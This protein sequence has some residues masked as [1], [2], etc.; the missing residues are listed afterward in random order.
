MKNILDKH[1]EAYEGHNQYDFD[2]NIMLN[3][4]PYRVIKFAKDAK[5]ILEW[6]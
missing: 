5:S 3:W 6:D 1:V 2:N 4:Y